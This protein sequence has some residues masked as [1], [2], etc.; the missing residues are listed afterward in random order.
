MRMGTYD[1]N[2]VSSS[3]DLP[4]VSRAQYI[5]SEHSPLHEI[6]FYA[7]DLHSTDQSNI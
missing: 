7:I 4:E 6:P 3:P 1:S 5:D 2:S